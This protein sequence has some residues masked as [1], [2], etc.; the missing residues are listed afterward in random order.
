MAHFITFILSRLY[1]ST[2]QRPFLLSTQ[3]LRVT[4]KS[5]QWPVKT[6]L[7]TVVDFYRKS[8]HYSLLT[9]MPNTNN[10]T[11]SFVRLDVFCTSTKSLSHNCPDGWIRPV[12][13][14]KMVQPVRGMQEASMKDQGCRRSMNPQCKC[15]YT[16]FSLQG[17][18]EHRVYE[19]L[20]TLTP[21]SHG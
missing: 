18:S 3:I 16:W 14:W 11:Q 19:H 10:F 4:V 1:R 7:S 13:W 21:G 6:E 17:C 15:S 9:L 12:C 8:S 2:A 20:W 5:F